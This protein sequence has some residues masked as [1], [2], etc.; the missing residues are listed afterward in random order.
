MNELFFLPRI[1]AY[2]EGV[3]PRLLCRGGG[4]ESYID[5]LLR[6]NIYL[7]NLQISEWKVDTTTIKSKLEIDPARQMDSGTYECQANNKYTVDGRAF[8]A[9]FSTIT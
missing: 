4:L 7:K 8:K 5:S 2:W 1:A 3:G 9:D 6:L